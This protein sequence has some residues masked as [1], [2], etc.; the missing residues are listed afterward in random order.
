MRS[1]LY[2]WLVGCGLASKLRRSRKWARSEGAGQA[3]A[4]GPRRAPSWSYE[5]L[6]DSGDAPPGEEDGEPYH[7]A[8]DPYRGSS[9]SYRTSSDTYRGYSDHRDGYRSHDGYRTHFEGNRGSVEGY[10]SNADRNSD[11]YRGNVETFRG[12]DSFRGGSDAFRGSSDPYRENSDTFQAESDTYRDSSDAF[13]VNSDAYQSNSDALAAESSF[14]LEP[15]QETEF[16]RTEYGMLDSEAGDLDNL[17]TEEG[18]RPRL[19]GARVNFPPDTIAPPRRAS[20]TT[21]MFRNRMRP[22]SM[23]AWSD[24]SRSSFKLEERYLYQYVII[25][26]RCSCNVT[27]SSYH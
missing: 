1:E 23:S 14:S 2:V 20:K 21:L 12:A 16:G 13:R 15:E 27:V 17:V 4:R 10:R 11:T 8:A 7:G 26:C 18:P 24:I 19:S 5:M 3:R 9:D 22:R 25:C 6:P